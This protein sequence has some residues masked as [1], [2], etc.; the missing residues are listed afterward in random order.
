MR[1]LTPETDF[2]QLELA[3][4]ALMVAEDV[5][6]E[7][8]LLPGLHA[9]AELR[10]QVSQWVTAEVESERIDSGVPS[11][12]SWVSTAIATIF[13]SRRTACSIRFWPNAVAFRCRWGLC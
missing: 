13:F 1:N 12:A 10:L 11:S 7:P 3:M 4:L 5:Q 2:E 8:V 9:L 6:D